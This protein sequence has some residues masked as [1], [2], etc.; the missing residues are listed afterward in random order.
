M[1]FLGQRAHRPNVIA[2]EQRAIKNNLL[3]PDEATAAI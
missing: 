1:G 3:L 2:N